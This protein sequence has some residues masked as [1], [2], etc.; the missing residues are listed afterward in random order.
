MSKYKIKNSL[1]FVL[2]EGIKIYFSNIDKFFIY[3]LFPV[4]GQVIGIIL[5]FAFSYK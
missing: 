4:L 1:W 2:F 5:A 3:M